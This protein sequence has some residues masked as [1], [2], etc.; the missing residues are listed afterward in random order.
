MDGTIQ[1]NLMD[2]N[3]GKCWNLKNK[4]NPAALAKQGELEQASEMHQ[5]LVS[6]IVCLRYSVLHVQA[7]GTLPHFVP[8][9]RLRLFNCLKSM[10]APRA[11]SVTTRLWGQVD[12][13]VELCRSCRMCTVFCPTGALARFDTADGSFGVEHRSTLCMQCRLCEVICPERAITVRDAVDLEEFLSGS[14]V[15]F[16]MLPVGWN[17]GQED[18]IAT[19]MAR[20]L[21]TDT[22]QEPQAKVG[23]HDVAERRSYAWERERRRREIRQ[24]GEQAT[25]G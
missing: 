18:A 14:K 3:K 10:G 6:F 11:D 13:D 15:R 24:A 7:D 4:I 21:K 5:L 12:L 2:K 22:L 9:R 17:P 19:R 1:T 8:E 23:A 25:R 16:A 20:Y